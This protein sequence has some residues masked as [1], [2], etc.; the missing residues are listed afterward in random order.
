[1][2]KNIFT[3]NSE[4][5]KGLTLLEILFSVIILTFILSS[6]L[7]IFRSFLVNSRKKYIEK[8]IFS[9]Y[10][11]FTNFLKNTLPYAM[12]NE[13]KGKYRINFKGEKTWMKFIIPFSEGENSDLTKIGVYFKE[14]KI[15]VSMER[16]KRKKMDLKF[17]E[18]F[19]GAQTLCENVRTL[20]FKY[21]DGEK[22]NEK[23]DTE[24]MEKP[25]LPKILKFEIEIYGGKIEG[26]EIRKYFFLN[27]F[28]P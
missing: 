3:V 6:S 20:K 12:V 9:E 4:K 5:N 11:T 24:I 14:G 16:V 15:K 17:S 25:V 23:W 2:R 7:L 26:K 21:F 22:W 28:F 13:M 27:V 10:S 1:M 8:K 19:P 18:G